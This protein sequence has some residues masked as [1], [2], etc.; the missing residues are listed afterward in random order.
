MASPA[1][2]TSPSPVASLPPV[3]W[4]NVANEETIGKGLTAYASESGIEAQGNS[5]SWCTGDFASL[6]FS[7]MKVRNFNGNDFTATAV[8]LDFP[9]ADQASAG[10]GAMRG[11]FS[12]CPDRLAQRGYSDVSLTKA[13]E[14]PA[15]SPQAPTQISYRTLSGIDPSNMAAYEQDIIIQA[16]RRIEWV[17]YK[18]T[19]TP[20]EGTPPTTPP[21]QMP[22]TSQAQALLDQLD[23]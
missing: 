3:S 6:G 9:D 13:A 1:A 20:A 5:T 7:S 2:T 22:G 11:W 21:D 23:D 10:R 8:V 18:A 15:S 14:I 4:A 12:S 17:S 16:G 19:G